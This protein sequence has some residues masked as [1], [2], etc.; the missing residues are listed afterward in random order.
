M[1]VVGVDWSGRLSGEQVHLW[2]AEGAVGSG[3][4]L[5]AGPLSGRTRV[6]VGDRLMALAE[7]DPDLV[8]GLDFGFSFP[9]WFLEEQGIACV[10]ELWNDVARL[11]AW[12]AQCQPPFW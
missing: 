11:E 8:V 2:M 7:S 9:A 12:L 10:D 4:G 5:V 1:R 6:A 3:T